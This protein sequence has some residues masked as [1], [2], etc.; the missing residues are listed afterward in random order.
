M[1]HFSDV[2]L[3]YDI[4]SDIFYRSVD[5]RLKSVESK[6]CLLLNHQQFKL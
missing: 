1:Q 5:K 6:L 2:A 3:F 4:F